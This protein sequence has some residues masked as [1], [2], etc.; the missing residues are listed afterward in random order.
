MIGIETGGPLTLPRK[1]PYSVLIY[2]DSITEGVRTMGYVGI[3]NDTDRNDAIRDYSYQLC[4]PL[5]ISLRKS[6]A[7]IKGNYK[8][9]PW[10][11]LSPQAIC[12]CL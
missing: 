12:R 5:T 2:G 4:K 7:K 10:S 1:R 11:T 6:T 9:I 3:Q 8:T